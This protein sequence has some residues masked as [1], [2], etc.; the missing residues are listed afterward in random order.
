MRKDKESI[1]RTF[2][3]DMVFKDR[4][5][6]VL[7]VKK[8]TKKFYDIKIIVVLDRKDGMIKRFNKGVSISPIDTLLQSYGILEKNEYE[9]DWD[10]RYDY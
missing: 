2:L 5:D 8:I 10:Y 6:I 4:N 3:N 9:L 1:I 7:E